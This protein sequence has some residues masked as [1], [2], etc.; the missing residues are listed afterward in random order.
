[1]PKKKEVVEEVVEKPKKA[2]KEAPVVLNGDIQE[3]LDR[4]AGVYVK[5][6]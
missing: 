6:K 4:K 5:K 3:C 2:E 1:M